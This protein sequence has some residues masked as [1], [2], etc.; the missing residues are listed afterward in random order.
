MSLLA[1]VLIPREDKL[2]AILRNERMEF[3]QLCAAKTARFC[4]LNRFQ[5]KLGI[6]LGLLD[7]DMPRLSSFATE[8]EETKAGNPEDLRHVWG[9]VRIR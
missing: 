5:P 8:K 6:T 4:Q 3:S 9:Y 1:K 7:V 2:V